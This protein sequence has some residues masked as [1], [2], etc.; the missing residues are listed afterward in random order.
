MRHILKLPV[1]GLLVVYQAAVAQNPSGKASFLP[2]EETFYFADTARYFE[3]TTEMGLILGTMRYNGDLSNDQLANTKGL[4]PA[5]GLFVRRHLWPNL[6]LRG[7]LL[8][9]KI[10]AND[11]DYT[12]PNWRQQRKYAFETKVT[13]LSLQAEWDIFGKKRFRRTDTVSYELDRYRQIAHVNKFKPT[14]APYLFAG[15]GLV[16]TKAN[17]LFDQPYLEES[18]LLPK[19]VEDLRIGSKT[20]NEPT[21]AFGAGVNLDLSRRWMLGLELGARS[22][23][24]DYFDGVSQSGNPDKP[25]WYWLVGV[26]VVY[27]LGKKDK[28]GDGVADKV[29]KCPEIAGFGRTQGCPDADHDGIADRDDECPHRYGVVSLGGC[30]IKDVDNDSIPDVDDQCPT[31]PGLAK[32]YGCPDTDGDGLEDRQ[33][34]C[35]TVAGLLQFHGC[36][37]TDGDGIEDRFDA[38]PLEAGP[39]DYY[40]GCPIRDTDRDSVEDKLDA[41]LLVP[42]KVEFKGCP[43]TDNDG[44]EDAL[45]I[46]PTIAGSKENKGCPVVEKKDREKLD[47]AVKA[48]KFQ[49]GK[50]ILKKESSKILTDIANILVKYP[51]YSLS[52]EGHTD[53]AGNDKANQVLS[54]KRALACLDFL[55]KK[56][57][58]KSRMQSAGFGET[59]PVADNKTAA[60][61][62]KNRRV[63][64]HLILMEKKG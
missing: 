18:G 27:R 20:Q 25:D 9:G 1:I 43:D 63:E 30:P 59:R 45:D 46:C 5:A 36:P 39:L 17:T 54:E 37:D 24:S 40:Y 53:S 47:L 61:K 48:V 42:G 21:L 51:H 44:V 22:A 38:C 10:A 4:K 50:S 34:S 6:A 56:G 60:G 11:L 12:D 32:F 33:D 62:T 52:M 28:D 64:F 55:I 3:K 41:C 23:F 49:T 8:F 35:A 14:L 13:E 19:A 58:D 57:I 31:I 7:N 16:I 26:N 29:D 15:G 2:K